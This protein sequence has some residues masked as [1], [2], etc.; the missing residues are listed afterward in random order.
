MA[1]TIGIVS[2]LYEE[3]IASLTPYAEPTVHS[4]YNLPY[5]M[6]QDPKCLQSGNIII[7]N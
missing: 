7:P 4:V 2:L 5:L 3:E 1:G 6:R